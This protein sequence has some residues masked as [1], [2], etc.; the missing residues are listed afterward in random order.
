MLRNAK[1]ARFVT[2]LLPT[3]V[4]NE[5]SHRVLLTFNATTL[6]EFIIRSK[7]LDEGT[8]AYLLPALLVPLQ[9]MSSVLSQ[10]SIVSLQ[11]SMPKK[12]TSIFIQ[13]GSY[14]LLVA[15]SQK[16]QL[17]PSALKLIVNAMAAC[18]HMVRGNQFISSLVAVCDSQNELERFSDTTSKAILRIP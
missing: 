14:I 1:L 2:S 13:I 11:N 10:D 5:V 8:M 3:A 15:L 16:C 12:A 7:E 17:S 6:H 18:A 9:Q 4:K